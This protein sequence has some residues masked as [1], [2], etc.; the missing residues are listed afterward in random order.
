MSEPAPA[1]AM[2]DEERYHDALVGVSVLKEKH[3]ALHQAVL[4]VLG[5]HVGDCRRDFFNA[6]FNPHQAA[7]IHARYAQ[8]DAVLRTLA[9]PQKFAPKKPKPQVAVTGGGLRALLDLG[10]RAA[11][12]VRATMPSRPQE[13]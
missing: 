9:N 7:V 4:H 12:A 11:A 3:P 13:A 5:K 2:T 10:R 1:R 8:L 6:E